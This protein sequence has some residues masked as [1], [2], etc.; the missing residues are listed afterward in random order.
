M[1]TLDVIIIGGG[2]AGSCLANGLLNNAKDLVNVTIYESDQ[3]DSNRDGYQIR[4]GSYALM[5]FRACLTESQYTDLL[6]CFGRSGGVVSSAPAIFDTNMKLVLDL[7]KFPAYHKSAPI[8][9]ARLRNLLQ[10]PLLKQKV[11][12]YGKTFVHYEVV[13]PEVAPDGKIRAHFSDGSS[14]D[15]DILI[16]AEG[17]RSRINKQLGCCNII[18]RPETEKGAV[19]GKCHVPW[20]VLR[21]LPHALVEKGSIYTAGRG[22]SIFSALYLPDNFTSTQQKPSYQPDRSEEE[23]S[24]YDETQASLMVSLT[25][26][27]GLSPREV[28]KLADP[29]G[30]M[31]QQLTEA[32]WHPNF[33]KL[34]DAIE[35][36]ALQAVP[37]RQA[38]DTPVDWRRRTLADK[39]YA[40]NPEIA[41]PRVWLI[42]DSFH[43]M[44][45]TRGMGAN[46]AIRDTADILGPLVALALHKKVHG[47]VTD[48]E[49]RTQLAVYEN[50]MI[51]RAMGWV[52]TSAKQNVRPFFLCMSSILEP[53][54]LNY[55]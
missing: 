5:G 9:R 1:V 20:S 24:H 39:V 13:G 31:R 35:P 46:N 34:V 19:L 14:A 18:D 55:V 21:D 15:C 37:L 38:K 33:M 2:L 44:L 50:A 6:L 22:C 49:A 40:S 25:W 8:G 16:S 3:Q 42:G 48:D 51:P 29:K 28:V 7:S 45:P 17:S 4:L 47:Q 26:T 36:D 32:N 53:H 23:P 41:H 10:A 12:H 52:K 27:G 54:R 30:Y 43:P 11:I